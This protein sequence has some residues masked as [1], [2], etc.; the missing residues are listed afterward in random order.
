MVIFLHCENMLVK[1]CA[2]LTSVLTEYA[3]T[4]RQM[5]NFVQCLASTLGINDF[6]GICFYGL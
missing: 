5:Q 1:P 6:L 2:L 4:L 3:Q